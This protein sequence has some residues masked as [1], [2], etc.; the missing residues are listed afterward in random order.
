M[1]KCIFLYAWCFDFCLYI[2]SRLIAGISYNIYH[3]I[4]RYG[5]LVKH[6]N[7]WNYMYLKP[8][9]YHINEYIFGLFFVHVR[10]RRWYHSWHYRDDTWTLWHLESLATRLFVQLLQTNNKGNI[11]IYISSTLLTFCNGNPPMSA[12]FDSQT[13]ISAKVVPMPCRHHELC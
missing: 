12:G 4:L 8:I 1:L 5:K 7:I 6:N 9:F 11:Y 10:L 13:A 3:N 2:F